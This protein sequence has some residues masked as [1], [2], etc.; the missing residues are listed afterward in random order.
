MGEYT[1]ALK[2][3]GSK[4]ITMALPRSRIQ[5][6]QGNKCFKCKKDLRPGFF[7]MVRDKE[8]NEQHIICSD[9][10]VEIKKKKY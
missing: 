1:D 8:T 3:K 10:L 5:K 6:A 9:C 4:E 7:T 2:K